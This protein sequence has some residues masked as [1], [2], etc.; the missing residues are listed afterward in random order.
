MLMY[1]AFLFFADACNLTWD[2]NT[3]SRLVVVFENGEN[4]RNTDLMVPVERPD[5]PDRF[6]DVPQ[7]L[8]KEPLSGRCYWEVNYSG[9]LIMAVSYKRIDRKGPASAFGRND[10]SWCL[11]CTL[12]DCAL[13]HNNSINNIPEYKSIMYMNYWPSTPS[14]LGVYLDS[15]AGTLSFYNSEKTPR[16]LLH[17]L[18]VKFTEPLYVGFR[19]DPAFP[20]Q[21]VVLTKF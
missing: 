15:E 18:H 20:S 6:D 1:F 10:V 19:F 5:H 9:F 4:L 16:V 13:V 3:A 17:R 2:L 7:V 14:K 21:M 11:I 8:C 12:E